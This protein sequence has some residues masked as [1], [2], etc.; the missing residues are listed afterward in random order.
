MGFKVDIYLSD[1]SGAF[2]KVNRNVLMLRLRDI[3]LPDNLLEV[4]HSYLAPRT[5][6]VVVNGYESDI[7]GIS[8]EFFQ[9]TVLGPRLWNSFF[10]PVDLPIREKKYRGA[11]FAD[12]LTAYKYFESAVDNSDILNDL[13]AC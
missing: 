4:F 6:S 5:A 10:A 3:G 13:R 12:D 9:G 8:N 7:F 1:I 2:D 11:K